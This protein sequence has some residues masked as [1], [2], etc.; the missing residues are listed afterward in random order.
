MLRLAGSVGASNY[1]EFPKDP[2]GS[3][4]LSGRYLYLQGT[5]SNSLFVLRR[6][7]SDSLSCSAVKAIRGKPF[8]F[9]VEVSGRNKCELPHRISCS[10]M[11]KSH[12]RRGD[13]IIQLSLADITDKW[14]V[15]ALDIP[16]ILCMSLSPKK[17]GGKSSEDGFGSIKSLKF[18]ANLSVRGAYSSVCKS[19]QV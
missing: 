6:T 19:I 13:K 10:N 1:I 2:K 15:V 7:M 17:K 11:Y 14:T 4:G 5:C 18:C 8:S 12:S 16:K 3:L 9:H